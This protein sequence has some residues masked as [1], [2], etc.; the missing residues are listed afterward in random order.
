MQLRVAAHDPDS[1][2]AAE[3]TRAIAIDRTRCHSMHESLLA[4]DANKQVVCLIS[5]SRVVS[6]LMEAAKA[7]EIH[8]AT[9]WWNSSIDLLQVER[10]RTE[11]ERGLI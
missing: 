10:K 7:A 2:D 8:T 1:Q 6:L 5:T 9:L 3:C 4:K 11:C